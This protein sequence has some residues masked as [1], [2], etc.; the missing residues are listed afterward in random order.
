MYLTTTQ[1]LV[2]GSGWE[3]NS[4]WSLPVLEVMFS[5]IWETRKWKREVIEQNRFP[6][7]VG[8]TKEN[9][10]RTKKKGREKDFYIIAVGYKVTKVV[11]DTQ[12]KTAIPFKFLSE[13]L[14]RAALNVTLNWVQGTWFPGYMLFTKIHGF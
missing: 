12:V 4:S 8:E 6:G 5:E 10:C 1:L 11:F 9:S 13:L 14:G 7:L 3:L 2:G